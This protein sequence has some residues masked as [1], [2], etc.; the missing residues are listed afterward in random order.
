MIKKQSNGWKNKYTLTETGWDYCVNP[1]D[2]NV[3]SGKTSKDKLEVSPEVKEIVAY[4]N[5]K[6]G[7][8]FREDTVTT[9]K[10]IGTVLHKGITVDECKA[11]IDLKVDQWKGNDVMEQHLTPKTLF[12]GKFKEYLVEAKRVK[13]KQVQ[14]V[15]TKLDKPCNGLELYYKMASAG[16]IVNDELVNEEKYRNTIRPTLSKEEQTV[17]DSWYSKGV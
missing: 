9:N 16:L 2:E 13:P 7:T 11:V 17:V 10:L 5:A 4:L 12:G 6:A 3:R 1:L 15:Q 8:Q 14:T